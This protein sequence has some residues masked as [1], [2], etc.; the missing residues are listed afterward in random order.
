M[1]GP[2]GKIFSAR[3]DTVV[4]PEQRPPKECLVALSDISARKE[5]EA[6]RA[7]LAAIRGVVVGRYLESHAGRDR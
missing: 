5:A 3:L 7:R 2:A 6:T 1:V 4:G